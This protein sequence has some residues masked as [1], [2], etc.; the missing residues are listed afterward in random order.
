MIYLVICSFIRNFAP[1][2][3]VIGGRGAKYNNNN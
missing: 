2:F 1:A 3:R